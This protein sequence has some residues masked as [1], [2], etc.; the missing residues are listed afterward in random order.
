VQVAARRPLWQCLDHLGEWER[1][2]GLRLR[3]ICRRR[4][5]SLLVAGGRL[6]TKGRVVASRSKTVWGVLTAAI[7]LLVLKV[8]PQKR[9]NVAR[10]AGRAVDGVLGLIVRRW[11]K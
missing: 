11:R 3:F 5:P 4:G 2:T 6:N 1:R 7:F 10:D 8:K 9:L